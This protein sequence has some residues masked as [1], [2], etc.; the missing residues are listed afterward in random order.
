LLLTSNR[1]L[2]PPLSPSLFP[3]YL[4]IDRQHGVP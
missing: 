4:S 3:L 2:A 1:L